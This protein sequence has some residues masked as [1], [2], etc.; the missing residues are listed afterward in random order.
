MIVHFVPW[1]QRP[2]RCLLGM[3]QWILHPA[4]APTRTL[5][6]NICADCQSEQI[7]DPTLQ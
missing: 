2:I 6:W 1:H 3:H 5:D 7:N 4:N